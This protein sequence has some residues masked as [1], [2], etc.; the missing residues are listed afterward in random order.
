MR[1]IKKVITAA[2]L[3]M[4]MAVSSLGTVKAEEMTD[5]IEVTEAVDVETESA[6]ADAEDLYEDYEQMSE[7]EYLEAVGL[8]DLPYDYEIDDPEAYKWDE[9]AKNVSYLDADSCTRKIN[10]K[11]AEILGLPKE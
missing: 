9:K 1:R 5:Q 7:R 4:C 11:T 8:G 6:E 10:S 3:T 2:V